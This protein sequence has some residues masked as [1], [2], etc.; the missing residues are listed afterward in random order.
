MLHLIMHSTN[1]FSYVASADIPWTI[2][3]HLLYVQSHKQDNFPHPS[4]GWYEK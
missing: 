4:T 1:F 3:G 2:H